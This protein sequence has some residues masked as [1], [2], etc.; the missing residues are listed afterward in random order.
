MGGLWLMAPWGRRAIVE[1]QPASEGG[2][3][4]RAVEVDGAVCPA[5]E[6]GS[7]EAKT[8]ALPLVWGRYGRVRRWRMASARQAI[9]CTVER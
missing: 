8:Q 9:A 3:A 6:H 7:D 2:V 1:V 4:F 5:A